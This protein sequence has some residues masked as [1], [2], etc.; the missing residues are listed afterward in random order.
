MLETTT[1][2]WDKASG[3]VTLISCITLST[4]R[5]ELVLSLFTKSFPLQPHFPCFLLYL[6]G[7]AGL[8]A[9]KK[10]VLWNRVL[11]CSHHIHCPLKWTC[12][13]PQV[14]GISLKSRFHVQLSLPRFPSSSPKNVALYVF[15][16]LCRYCSL[17]FVPCCVPVIEVVLSKSGCGED[18]FGIA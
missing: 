7:N 2:R 13:D 10:L 15:V 18:A 16:T 9:F 11:V 3:N 8:D 6:F 14:I 4:N 1:K 17:T 5:N 12:R